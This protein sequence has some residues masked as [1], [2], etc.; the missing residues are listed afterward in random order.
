V[1]IYLVIF[2]HV[3]K[4]AK[5]YYSILRVCVST[6]P[7]V[8]L[9]GTTRLP[10]DGFSLNLI[11]QY[12]FKSV[13]KIQVSFKSHK[14]NWYFTWRRILYTFLPCLTQ[15]FLEWELFQIKVAVKIIRIF[16]NQYL[17]FF[18]ELCFLWDNV[19]KSCRVGEATDD[20]VA[21]AHCMLDT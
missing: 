16:Y 5:N 12:F 6:R 14:N 1:L 18:F 4:I 8:H 17:F 13:E 20:N 10:L 2:R 15:F 7:S 3:H 21:H 9:H 19:E 11:F